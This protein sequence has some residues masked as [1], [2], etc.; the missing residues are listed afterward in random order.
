MSIL[1]RNTGIHL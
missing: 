1:L